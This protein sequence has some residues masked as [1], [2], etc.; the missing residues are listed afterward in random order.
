MRAV[1]AAGAQVHVWTVDEP[2]RMRELLAVG[3]DGIVTNR[4][5]L[6]LPVTAAVGGARP[7]TDVD[8]DS[9]LDSER[10]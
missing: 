7:R 6:A 10:W 8:V 5:D 9:G 3:V 4:A 2:A 1:H